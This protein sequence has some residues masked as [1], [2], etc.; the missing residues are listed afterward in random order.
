MRARTESRVACMTSAEPTSAPF[1]PA[2][3]LI[4]SLTAVSTAA[5]LPSRAETSSPLAG[6]GQFGRFQEAPRAFSATVA[7]SSFRLAK[8]SR[9]SGATEAGSS[10]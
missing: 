1:A 10:E 9:H 5:Q 6:I 4:L 3:A 2:F 8:N 7:V